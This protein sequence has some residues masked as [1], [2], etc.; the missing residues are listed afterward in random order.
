MNASPL[1][2]I[3][4]DGIMKGSNGTGPVTV[5]TRIE[6]E[7]WTCLMQPLDPVWRQALIQGGESQ[8]P[9]TFDVPVQAFDEFPALPGSEF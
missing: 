3:K 4:S 8:R 2:A 1:D 9:S 5:V 6:E 7:F